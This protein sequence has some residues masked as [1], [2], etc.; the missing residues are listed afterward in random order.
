MTEKTSLPTPTRRYLPMWNH[1]KGKRSAVTCAL[2]CNNACLEPDANCSDN[3]YF[4]DIIEQAISR[5]AMLG[6]AGA[7]LVVGAGATNAPQAQAAVPAHAQG[8]GKA[9]G[10]GAKDSAFSFEPIAPVP[11]DVDDFIVPTG[12]EWDPIIRWGDPLFHDT[13]AFDVNNQIAAAQARQ[14]GFN[15]DYLTVIVDSKNPLRGVLVCN[16]EYVN[17]NTMFPSEAWAADSGEL[18]RVAMA[19]QGMSVV[20]LRRT[21]V[22]SP[23]S[24][25]VGGRRNR[26]ITTDTP[27]SITGPA[28]GSKLLKTAADPTGAVVLGTNNN[29]SGGLT[30]WGTVLSGEENFDSYF[31]GKDT[32][33][34]KRY[35]IKNAPT[36]HGWEDA[37]PRFNAN[38]K[39]FENE[40]HRFGYIV[41]L[42]PENPSAPPRKHTALGRFKHE[43]ANIHVDP[44]TGKVAAY[45]GD[46]SRF[47]YM[48]K[49]VSRDR[50]IEGNRKHN[51]TLLENGSLF[52]A[53]FSGNSPEAEID[54][55]GQLPADGRFDGT[56]EWIQ[57]TNGKK[58][59][60]P[61]M[62]IDEVLVFTRI[63]ADKMQPT[64]M[65]R[66]EDVEPSPLTGKIYAALTN[67]TDRGTV[68]DGKQLEGATEPN[69]RNNN[70]DGHVIEI[71]EDGNRVDAQTFTWDLLLVCGDPATETQTYFAGYDI[72]QVS[73]ISCPDNVAFDSQGNLWISTDGAPDKIQFNDGLFKV[74]VEGPERGKVEQFLSVP[75]QA[76]TCG[77]VINDLEHM[78]YVCVQ[79]PGEDGVFEEPESYFPDFANSSIGARS[80]N[81]GE[82]FGYLPH[83]RP[84]VVQVYR[85]NQSQNGNGKG[86]G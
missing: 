79:H 66:P 16:H 82:R 38:N 19:A 50:Y 29:C 52:V 61:G 3:H 43:G 78:V 49:F 53:R 35:T 67:N 74:P 72:T 1:V 5:R 65:D 46:D 11:A 27:F 86:R 18:R 51:M 60:V 68:K 40:S 4:K 34:F 76:E 59:L 21:K 84:S 80:S 62:S 42:D 22:G 25:I 48:Y 36:P 31:V 28:K 55:S 71:T 20:E 8:K 63:A 44:V 81:A 75:K 77:P 54:G 14:F 13:P 58:S 57:L 10:R 7:A 85:T 45:M 2:K 73:P 30:P 69:P 17:E 47:E 37:D 64:K 12:Y 32:P 33:E 9:L 56:G 26:R 39:G 23:W 41:E 15:N 70:R 6:A 24:Y 83:P